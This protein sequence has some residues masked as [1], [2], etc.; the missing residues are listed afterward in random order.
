M[1]SNVSFVILLVAMQLVS[2]QKSQLR[3]RRQRLMEERLL[4]RR[5]ERS[6]GFL[7]SWPSFEVYYTNDSFVC[8]H[9]VHSLFENKGDF[10][11][12]YSQMFKSGLHQIG[13][14]NQ[15]SIM[16]PL[17]CSFLPVCPWTLT[18]D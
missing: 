11:S 3:K 10:M 15:Y 7:S 16:H 17:R 8:F 12:V 2:Q 4:E 14:I 18:E 13:S 9:T 1:K 6:S 5:K